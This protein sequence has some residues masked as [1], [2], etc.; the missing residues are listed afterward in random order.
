MWRLAANHLRQTRTQLHS[1]REGSAG[2]AA[3]SARFI[4]AYITTGLCGMAMYAHP[5]RLAGAPCSAKIDVWAWA[6]SLGEAVDGR[7]CDIGVGYQSYLGADNSCVA[8]QIWDRGVST[9]NAEQVWDCMEKGESVLIDG[10]ASDELFDLLCMVSTPAF[11]FRGDMVWF[12]EAAASL[13][14]W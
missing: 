3:G 9:E 7:V 6:M 12:G 14:A 2:W 11:Q 1:E 4:G 8:S 5:E 13:S 10:D